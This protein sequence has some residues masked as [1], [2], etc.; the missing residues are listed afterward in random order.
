[1]SN[2]VVTFFKRVADSNGHE[3]ET[4]QDAIELSSRTLREAIETATIRFAARRHIPNWRLH[5][6]RIAIALRG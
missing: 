5:A 6:D 2:Y 3:I 1:M 4:P